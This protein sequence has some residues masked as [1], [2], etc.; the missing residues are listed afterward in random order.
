MNSSVIRP[1]RELPLSIL[2]LAWIPEGSNAAT[3]LGHSRDLVQHAE[4]WGF[5]RHWVA[6]HH[7]MPGVACTATAVVLGYLAAATR[8]I[9]VGSGGVMLPNHA[10]LIIAEQFGTLDT[11]YPG[12]I[13]LGLGR[14]PGTDGLTVRALRRDPANAEHF[15][16]DV[17][18]LQYFFDAEAARGRVQAVPAAGRNVPIWILGSSTWGAQLAAAL[19]LPFAFAA[20]FAPRDLEQ[21]LHLYRSGFKPSPQLERPYVMVGVH[22]YAADTDAEARLLA[23]TLQQM[24]LALHAG[25]PRAL[26]P[27]RADLE[28]VTPAADLA[29]VV[30]TM[31]YASIG[32][33]D[34]VLA[35]L[36]EIA[37]RTQADELIIAAPMFDHAARMHSYELIA[38][39][40]WQ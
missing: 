36:A 34:R 38:P 32:T 14:A 16:S 9:R 39:S 22:V 12:R 28:Q 19:G 23:T 6:E 13:D 2:D 5:N 29:G 37:G 30:A 17:Q 7:N 40:T 11:L 27:P 8:R 15:A 26:Q 31:R 25:R 18:E 10:P 20:H 3:A 35:N 1:L 33:R 24:F 21:A 4:S